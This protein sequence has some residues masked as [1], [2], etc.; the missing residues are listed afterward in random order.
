M[1]LMKLFR[2]TVPRPATQP[3]LHQIAID[4]LMTKGTSFAIGLAQEIDRDRT[5]KS[6]HDFEREFRLKESERNKEFMLSQLRLAQP[7]EYDK[8]ANAAI[9]ANPQVEIDLRDYRPQMYVALHD[10][11]IV[12]LYGTF[13]LNIIVP[14]GINDFGA[15]TGHTNL[16]I[17]R[18]SEY[19]TRGFHE[20]TA[21]H[22]TSVQLFVKRDRP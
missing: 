8:W 21:H 1:K 20:V 12:P 14:K 9:K 5:R 3:D 17:T 22:P 13:A 7:E 18:N 4:T 16:Y 15:K 2:R 10:L 19:L 11:H 6:T